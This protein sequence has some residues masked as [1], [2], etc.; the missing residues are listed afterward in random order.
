MSLLKIHS[1]S[2]IAT[3]EQ[4]YEFSIW[5]GT[6]LTGN[7]ITIQVISNQTI[8]ANFIRSKY[9]LTIDTVGSGEVSQQIVNSARE[10]TEYESGKTIRLSATPQ[11]DFLFDWEYLNNNQS[12]NSYENPIEIIMDQSKVVTATFEEKLPLINQDNTDKNNTVGKWKIRKKRPGSQR[13][14]S[15]KN[16]RLRKLRILSSDPTIHLQ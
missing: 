7:S 5:T 3:P 14:P 15:A 6:S 4:G 13:A 16:S 10:T 8:T 2:I 11:S 12:D 9:T 1:V